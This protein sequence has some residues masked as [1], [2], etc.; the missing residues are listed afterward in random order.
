[1]SN[2]AMIVS[3]LQEMHLPRPAYLFEI[4]VSCVLSSTTGILMQQSRLPAMMT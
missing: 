3:V 4:Y 1:M 2:I